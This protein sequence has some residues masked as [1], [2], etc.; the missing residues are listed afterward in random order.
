MPEI[1]EMAQK[2][3]SE[4]S[5][6]VEAFKSRAKKIRSSKELAVLMKPLD[7]EIAVKAASEYLGL[8]EHLAM[9]IDGSMQIDELLEMFIF[10]ANATAYVCPFTVSKDHVE[11]HLDQ[12]SRDDR[13]SVSATVP[14]WME[15]LSE[16]SDLQLLD[17]DYQLNDASSKVTFAIMTMAELRTACKAIDSGEV[18]ILFLDR[19][20]SGTFP[21]LARDYRDLLRLKRFS[22]AG[23]ETPAGPLTLLDMAL[24]YNLGDGEN[25]L[26]PRERFLPYVV[27]K[28]LLDGETH[29]IEEIGKKLNLDEKVLVQTLKRLRR[30][31][32]GSGNLLLSMG[33]RDD[34]N[35]LRITDYARDYWK[36]V[37]F[38]LN[39]I[40]EKVFGGKEHP[41]SLGG[42]RWLSARDLNV[43]NTLM[44]YKLRKISVEKKVLVVGI[45]KDTAATDLGRAVIPFA[46]SNGLIKANIPW[47]VRSDRV[48]LGVLST[49]EDID[50]PVPWRTMS[51]DSIF[52]TLIFREMRTPNL[53]AARRRASSE[54]F[55]A[56][57]YFQLRSLESDSRSKSS[58]FMYDRFQNDTFDSR[59]RQTVQ[60]SEA[61]KVCNANIYF[62]SQKRNE[63]DEL[64]LL[65]LSLSDNPHVAE[66]FGHNQLLFLADKAVK[67]EARQARSMLKGIVWL[68][69]GPLARTDRMFNIARRFRD[70]RAE[71]ERSRDT[72]GGVY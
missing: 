3:R 67:A 40:L 25:Y 42:E 13:L 33:G 34:E 26:P 36:R 47:V 49:S 19:P 30:I 28:M 5:T 17:T 2:L 24:A 10:Y 39:W 12:V 52:T 70:I 21:P 7:R 6:L 35:Q 69:I 43:F 23:M 55:F 14:L 18:R 68:E 50:V 16:I 51:Y 4:T 44:M 27:V 71:Y 56:R 61:N 66:A 9:G 8:G 57:G 37:D 62:E 11:F 72:G 58:V 53:V 64:I 22:L 31:D 45:A 54:G 15:D 32:S 29:S 20:M 63:L 1:D 60:I 48:L 46:A 41:L 59:H 65:I 38:A